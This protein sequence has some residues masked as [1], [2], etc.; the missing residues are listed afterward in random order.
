MLNLVYFYIMAKQKTN[1]NPHVYLT[2]RILVSSARRAGLKA[3]KEAM[4]L[5][6]YIVVAENGWVIK[7]YADGSVEQL[8][9]IEPAEN[10]EVAFD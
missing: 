7:K 5:M 2:K 8:E 9:P 10:V 6:G 4:Q 1:G 3:S